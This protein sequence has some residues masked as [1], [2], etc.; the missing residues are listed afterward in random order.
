LQAKDSDLLAVDAS[1]GDET[2][3][4]YEAMVRAMDKNVARILT[5]LEKN[6]LRDNTIV[7]F[8]SDNGATPNGSNRPLRGGK[9]SVWEGGTRVPTVVHWPGAKLE[10]HTWTGLCGAMDLMPT[11]ISMAGL[12]MPETRPLDGKNI[13]PALRESASSPVDSYYWVWHDRDAIRTAD[14]RMHRF[15]HRVELYNMQADPNET[16]EVSEKHPEMVRLL[17]QKMD[18]W[19]QSLNAALSHL[20]VPK[21]VDAEPNP[22]GEILEVKVTVSPTALTKHTLVVPFASSMVTQYASDYIEFDIA[23]SPDSLESGF[24]YTPFKGND[25]ASFSLTFR[26]GEGLD[27]FGREQI[28]APAPQ[29]APGTWEHR[30]IGLCSS[31]PGILPRHGLV[32]RGGKPGIYTVYLDNLRIRHQDGSNSPIWTN[33]KDTRSPRIEDSTLFSGVSVRAVPAS[34]VLRN[35]VQAK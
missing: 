3:R 24:F 10:Q 35:T 12:S 17:T 8:S 11:L 14:W 25:Q 27:Q 31:A 19:S 7:L 15:S 13:W 21:A 23:R 18:A 29:G 34:A 22:E 33:G 5:E 26:R 16:T 2:K 1:V 20:P 9:H 30:V 6:Q 32:F 4:T 28:N